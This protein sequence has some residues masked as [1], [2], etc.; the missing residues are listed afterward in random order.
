MTAD[1]LRRAAALMRDR[2]EA[3]TQ[4]PWRRVRSGG[5]VVTDD[6]ESTCNPPKVLLVADRTR[7]PNTQHIASW[8]PAVALAVADWLDSE[9]NRWESAND[10]H[11]W[12]SLNHWN[13]HND[14]APM[15]EQTEAHFRATAVEFA[16]GSC[17]HALAVARAYLGEQP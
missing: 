8:H 6:A 11:W 16:D 15:P 14:D 5:M 13:E 7:E 10:R 17:R 4:G 9:A 1:T 2:A 12:I 3:A